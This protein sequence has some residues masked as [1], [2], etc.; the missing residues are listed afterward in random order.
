MFKDNIRVTDYFIV[1]NEYFNRFKFIFGVIGTRNTILIALFRAKLM[2]S[3]KLKLKGQPD[4]T[5]S[6]MDDYFRFWNKSVGSQLV[7]EKNSTR[8]RINGNIIS[9]LFEN[10]KKVR[11]YYDSSSSASKYGTINSISEQFFMKQYQISFSGKIVVDIGANIGDSA[12]AAALSGATHV[13]AFE[14]Y[15][16][17]YEMARKNIGLNSLGKKITIVNSGCGGRSTTIRIDDSFKS[18]MSSDIKKSKNGKKISI[19]TLEEITKKYKLNSG[20]LKLD[21]EGCEYGVI[22]GSSN[23]ILRKFNHIVM[24]YHYGYVN[25]EKK[26]VSAGFSVTHTGPARVYSSD[27]AHPLQ[28]FGMLFATRK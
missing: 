7:A 23:E 19:F 12:I 24:E 2:S 17:S 1:Y 20:I 8:V 10:K 14:P 4:F 3:I 21:C 27:S 11:L 28:H 18:S 16:Y 6:N 26:L 22:L 13:Y 5:I 9:F 25:I 15:P